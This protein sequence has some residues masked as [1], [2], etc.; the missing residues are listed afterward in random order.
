MNEVW[1]KPKLIILYRGRPEESILAVC[2]NEGGGGK[3]AVTSKYGDCTRN[4]CPG[5]DVIVDT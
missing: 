1:Q 4:G 2:K 3:L 5:C